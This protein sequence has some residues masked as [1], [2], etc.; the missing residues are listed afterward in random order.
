M[1]ISRRK[2][3]IRMSRN[4]NPYPEFLIDE[5]SG[6]RVPDIRHQIWA[7]G[8][9][10]GREDRQA[11]KSVIKSQD[12]TVMVFDGNGEQIPEYQ[13]RYQEVKEGI[14]K[15]APPNAVFGCFPNCETELKVVPREEW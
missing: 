10:A 6:I 7:E 14:L 8:Y 1:H 13:G 2:R 5:A 15:D 4:R 12:G 11:I 9:L 3:G